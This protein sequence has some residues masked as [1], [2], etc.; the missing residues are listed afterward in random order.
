MRRLLQI[1]LAL[2]GL[3]LLA[4]GAG[5]AGFV[6]S[7][8]TVFT[9]PTELAA[10]GRP[11]LTR[12]DLLGDPLLGYQGLELTLRAAA[13]RGVFIATAHP[14]DVADYLGS[15]PHVLLDQVTL[16]GVRGTEVAGSDAVSRPDRA[17]FWTHAQSGPDP[18][19]LSLQAGAGEQWVIAP[20][21]PRGPVVVSLGG[22]V[23]GVF[24]AALAVA[25]AGLLLLVL[26]VELMLRSGRRRGASRARASGRRGGGR[27]APRHARATRTTTG[28]V[29]G[30]LALTGCQQLGGVPVVPLQPTPAT[31]T[32]MALTK[33]ALSEDELPALL[34]SYDERNNAA[35]SAAG[36]PAFDPSRWR[37]ADRGPAL[38]ADLFGTRLAQL[39]RVGR[40]RPRT[41]T[42]VGVFSPRF[43]S[44]PMW[45]LVAARQRGVRGPMVEAM[46]FT[47]DSVTA[48]W[49][50]RA[51][52][53]VD[54]RLLPD[55]AEPS[56]VPGRGVLGPTQQAAEAWAAYLEG[57]SPDLEVDEETRTWRG[58]VEE[59]AGRPI[60]TQA[61]TRVEPYAPDEPLRVVRVDGGHLAVVTVRVTTALV[62]RRG[63]R[64]HWRPPLDR[65][66]RSREGVLTFAHLA[67]GLV[68]LPERGR[69][70]LL[71]SGFREVSAG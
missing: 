54:A 61:R 30:V 7:D 2:G 56:P 59:L 55:P 42:G 29:V 64:V 44:Y 9:P 12:A 16:S 17:G 66:R 43:D 23:D 37:L 25:G 48:P 49:L 52:T 22:T 67:T 57:G 65:V 11:V 26:A 50:M 31:P 18:Q 24:L 28:A 41:H 1:L 20:L 6:G 38:E 27:K 21:G 58:W 40:P 4:C 8:D 3:V 10:D 51:G 69:P 53:R 19:Q 5:V 68:L 33:V 35:V 14:V 34:A 13:A 46:V 15:A 63:L 60:F 47:R 71:G 32:E 45:T 39:T 70:R 62:G 36:P